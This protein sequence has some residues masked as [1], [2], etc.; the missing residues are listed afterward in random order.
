MTQMELALKAENQKLQAKLEIMQKISTREK[1]YVYFFK[2]CSQHNTRQEAFEY[3]NKIH[4]DYFG[5]QK[6]A[7]YRAFRK[8][9]ER[10]TK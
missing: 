6:F 9:C 8:Y 5:E 3:L 10:K 7:S 4:A 2:I 1:F